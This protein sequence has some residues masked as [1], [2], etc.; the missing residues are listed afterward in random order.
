MPGY[1]SCHVGHATIAHF[2]VIFIA[3]PCA[4]GDGEGGGMR[5]SEGK[6]CRFYIILRRD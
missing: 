4:S 1:N 5:P 6:P 2:D 3:Y